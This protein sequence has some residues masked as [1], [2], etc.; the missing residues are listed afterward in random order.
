M[1]AEEV[2]VVAC[3]KLFTWNRA[4]TLTSIVRKCST[5]GKQ[6]AVLFAGNSFVEFVECNRRECLITRHNIQSHSIEEVIGNL[7]DQNNKLLRLHLIYLRPHV[8]NNAQADWLALLYKCNEYI[9]RCVYVCFAGHVVHIEI[10]RCSRTS[11]HTRR[12]N[13]A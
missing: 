10:V 6:R 11:L 2:T 1:T 12:L 13:H 9:A 7:R 4:L 3:R 5:S 8:D